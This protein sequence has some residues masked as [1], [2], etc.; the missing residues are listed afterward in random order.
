MTGGVMLWGEVG[1]S[2]GVSRYLKVASA[3]LS[4]RWACVKDCHVVF[5]QL[6]CLKCDMYIDNWQSIGDTIM[7]SDKKRIPFSIFAIKT[8]W[9]LKAPLKCDISIDN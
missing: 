7:I 6:S 3:N 8:P 9:L 2:K 5:K 4:P 1:G